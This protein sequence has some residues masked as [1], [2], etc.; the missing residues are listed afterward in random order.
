MIYK[1]NKLIIKYR[2]SMEEKKE[3]WRK[4]SL[5]EETKKLE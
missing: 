1:K 4:L 2:K 3:S 5:R